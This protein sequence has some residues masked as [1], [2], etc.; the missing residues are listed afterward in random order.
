MFIVYVTQK[1]IYIDN[2]INEYAGFVERARALYIE[3]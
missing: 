2:A 1:W 3:A